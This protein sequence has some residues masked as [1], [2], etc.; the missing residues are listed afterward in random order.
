MLDVN[1]KIEKEERKM[2]VNGVNGAMKFKITSFV[3]PDGLEKEV[4]AHVQFNGRD[5]IGGGPTPPKSYRYTI[6]KQK[7]IGW[8][9]GLKGVLQYVPNGDYEDGVHTTVGPRDTMYVILDEDLI[10]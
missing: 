10:L 7:P 8:F 9:G 1:K 3:Y 6:H 4:S 2:P 5:M